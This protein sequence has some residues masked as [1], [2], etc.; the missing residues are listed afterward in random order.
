M[1]NHSV[2]GEHAVWSGGLEA[3]GNASA[4]RRSCPGFERDLKFIVLEKAF[5]TQ[6]FPFPRLSATED[7]ARRQQGERVDRKG[8]K[9][10]A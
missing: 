4:L 5:V 9:E 1:S 6:D 7:G 2:K 10:N 3:L 8:L